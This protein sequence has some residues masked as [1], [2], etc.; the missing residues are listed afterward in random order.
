VEFCTS[1]SCGSHVALSRHPPSYSA[2]VGDTLGDEVTEETATD[3]PESIS[4]ESK[5][6]ALYI[7]MPLFLCCYGGSCVIYCVHKIIRNCARAR[8]GP[9]S[10][11]EAPTKPPPPRA[12]PVVVGPPPG[13]VGDGQKRPW[14]GNKVAPAPTS[15]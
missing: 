6:L 15:V 5:R 4:A 8:R 13:G 12:V 10:S 14:S 11:V 7:V 1:A 2:D 9:P 3:A